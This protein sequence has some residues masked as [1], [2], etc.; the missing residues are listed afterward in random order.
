MLNLQLV[1]ARDASSSTSGPEFLF[2]EFL[3]YSLETSQGAGLDSRDPRPCA[4][5][6]I[7]RK[8][9]IFCGLITFV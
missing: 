9:S 3:K 7:V 4:V 8:P 5:K 2:V 6:S 1:R